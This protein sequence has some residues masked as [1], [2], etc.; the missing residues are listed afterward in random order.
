MSN[1]LG[2][3]AYYRYTDDDGENFSYLTDVGLATASG[4]I[5]DDT[6]PSFPRR[7]SP[8]IVYCEAN[9]DGRVA[10]KALIVPDPTSE[11]YASNVSQ[12]VIIEGTTFTTTGRRGERRSFAS[13]IAPPTP[14]V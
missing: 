12:S 1:T 4:A 6:R 2:D 3:R 9:V 14:P 10:R 5:L 11:L 8:R 7:F 13:N